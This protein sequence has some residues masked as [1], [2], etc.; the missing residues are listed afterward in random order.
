MAE[1]LE[2]VPML[3]MM[4]TDP[5]SNTGSEV[6][7]KMM[8]IRELRGGK[9]MFSSE[10][11]FDTVCCDWVSDAVAE[12]IFKNIKKETNALSFG[13]GSEDVPF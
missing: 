9:T 11:S 3:L 13:D 8:E 4:F 7:H 12:D 2:N 1:E 5:L 10:S 6:I